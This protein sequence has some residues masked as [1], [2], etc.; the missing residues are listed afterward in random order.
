MARR[1]RVRGDR[2][3]SDVPLMAG[4]PVQHLLPACCFPVPSLSR[5]PGRI[6]TARGGR[7]PHRFIGRGRADLESG[8][9]GGAGRPCY[10]LWRTA[11][12][13]LPAW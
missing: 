8:T 10:A 3:Y 7:R 6:E 12:E 11:A 9:R 1:A 5:G 4:D 13:G 2:P